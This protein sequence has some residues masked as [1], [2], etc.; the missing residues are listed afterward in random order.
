MLNNLIVPIVAIIASLGD[1]SLG[2]F[3]FGVLIVVITMEAFRRC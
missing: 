1:F 2:A 3:G